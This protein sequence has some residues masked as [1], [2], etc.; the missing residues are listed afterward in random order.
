MSD[1]RGG[2]PGW[3]GLHDDS[4]SM[5]VQQYLEAVACSFGGTSKTPAV[6]WEPQRCCCSTGV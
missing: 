2:V 1:A 6:A 4:S 5:R 3:P